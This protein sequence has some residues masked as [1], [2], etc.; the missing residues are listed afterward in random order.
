M[1]KKKKMEK[2]AYLG[3]YIK[4]KFYANQ[5]DVLNFQDVGCKET[6]NQIVAGGFNAPKKELGIKF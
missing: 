4:K 1:K 5:S 3:M 2:R 6:F